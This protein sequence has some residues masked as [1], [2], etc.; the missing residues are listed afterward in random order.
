MR[1][2]YGP[3]EIERAPINA[4]RHG[5]HAF[6]QQFADRGLQHPFAV[7]SNGH[8]G[9]QGSLDIQI[10]PLRKRA[11]ALAARLGTDIEPSRPAVTRLMKAGRLEAGL[12]SRHRSPARLHRKTPLP[13]LGK[14]VVSPFHTHLESTGASAPLQVETGPALDN[15]A[16]LDDLHTVKAVPAID[17]DLYPPRLPVA[18]G[19]HATHRPPVQP[20]IQSDSVSRD[21]V[22]PALPQRFPQ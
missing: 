8:L 21:R 2:G 20:K 4:K 14:R 6:T 15:T 19:D 13:L 12:V 17:P 9:L 22:G 3:R 1:F 18:N 11:A 10:N 5:R 7:V 16:V